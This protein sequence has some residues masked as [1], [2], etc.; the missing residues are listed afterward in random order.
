M[1]AIA[2]AFTPL[3]ATLLLG[4]GGGPPWF[5]AG[6]V[7]VICLLSLLCAR[8]ATELPAPART[9]ESRSVGPAPPTAST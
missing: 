9:P 7:A 6:A 8:A 5:V 4:A 3:V 2:G 1:S